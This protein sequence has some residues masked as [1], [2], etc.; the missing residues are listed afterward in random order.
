MRISLFFFKEHWCS[1]ITISGPAS[2]EQSGIDKWNAKLKC[3][4]VCSLI[5]NVCS[6]VLELILK[7]VLMCVCV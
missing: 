7:Y 3:I 2:V 5:L 6:S 1:D 4:K